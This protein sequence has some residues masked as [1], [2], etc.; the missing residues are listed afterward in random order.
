M[1]TDKRFDEGVESGFEQCVKA[2]TERKK[3]AVNNLRPLR[4]RKLGLAVV[5]S[6]ASLGCAGVVQ[7]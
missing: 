4:L 5:V 6:E 1:R 2:L 3:E 7:W